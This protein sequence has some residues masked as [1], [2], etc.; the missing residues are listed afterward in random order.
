[1]DGLDLTACMDPGEEVEMDT[2]EEAHSPT[3]AA[4]HFQLQLDK[5]IPSQIRIAE[6]NPE[7]D[8]LAMVTEDSKIFLHRFNWQR[9][10]TV[11]PDGKMIAVGLEDGSI[12]LHD[13]ENGKLLRSIK[14]HDAAV[15]C[16]NWEEDAQPIGREESNVSPYEDRTPRF[17]PP[18]PRIP[19]MP[20][21]SSGDR[22]NI[23]CSGDNDGDIC[24]SIFGIF[25]IGKIEPLS[26]DCFSIR[27]LSED[28]NGGSVLQKKDHAE[29][30]DKYLH[31]KDSHVGLHCLRLDTSIFRS[32]RNELYQVALQ[33]SS[34][35]D[36]IEV[37]RASLSVM[38]KQW[39]DA[40]S[41][42]YEKFDSLASLII[43]HG[44][45]SSPEEEFLSLLLGARSSPPLHQFLVNSLGEVGLKRVIKAVDGAGKEL[46]LII[47]E[48]LQP[49]AEI[50]GFRIGELRGLSRWRS[51]YH[52]VGLDEKLIDNATERAGI[53]LVQVERF[54]RVLAIVIHEACFASF[55]VLL[56]TE[57]FF[58]WLMRCIKLLM[59]ESATPVS[60]PNIELIITFLKFHYNCDP[61]KQLL[62]G[63]E[64]HDIEVDVD[65]MRRIEELRAFGGFLDTGY[66]RRTLT[67]EF[68]ELENSLKEAFSMPFSTISRR[69]C[70]EDFLPLYPISSPYAV[71]SLNPPASVSYF[72][73]ETV[74]TST[75]Y[76]S[77]GRH[78]DYICFKIPDDSM[79]MINSIGIIK[80]F[81][82]QSGTIEEGVSS[83]QAIVIRVPSD[84]E[85]IDLSPYKD[86]QI[87]LLLNET[88]ATSETPGNSCMMMFRTENLPFVSISRSIREDLWKLH[89]LKAFA[90]DLDLES[91]KL[92]CISHSLSAPLAV[93]ASRGVACVFASRKR[94]LVYILDEDEDEDEAFDA[95]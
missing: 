43:D 11:S 35:E 83:L 87:V 36:L 38:Y 26:I 3:A 77:G 37:I 66:L 65:T 25:S 8:L 79:D 51:R 91:G 10:W 46:N 45:D 67:K 88:V 94:A 74:D 23:L 24:F 85:C 62:E 30:K 72:K 22:F 4:V 47:R 76:T 41:T 20:G 17:F 68:G 7:K 42:F 89:E 59:S 5:P 12:A 50:I 27:G 93:S 49:A 28:E 70:C 54:L 82:S 55:I 56:L 90:V 48:H 95:E 1:M 92:R 61:V 18:A 13:V 44:L 16:L 39:S 73:D 29:L 31:L 6:W 78:V 19:Q 33:A 86:G 34:I 52:S 40:M 9:L 58:S 69:I 21:L 14:S 84:Y 71:T 81:S 32:R 57:K 53:L 80:R 75:C 15:V 2:E 60:L 64:V 63:S